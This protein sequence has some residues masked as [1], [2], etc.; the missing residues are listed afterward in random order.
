MRMY[1]IIIKKRNG[2]E[3]TKEEI[4]FFIKGYTDGS[5]PDYQA[6]AL[7]MAIYFQGMNKRE[8]AELTMAMV[9]SGA[10]IDLS[11]ITGVKVD[12]HSTG[13]VGDETSI[14][15][16]NNKIALKLNIP[17]ELKVN[18]KAWLSNIYYQA[19]NSFKPWMVNIIQNSRF[20][21]DNQMLSVTH[22]A[23]ITGI[24]NSTIKSYLHNNSLPSLE[25]IEAIA[26][27]FGTEIESFF[28]FANIKLSK[29]TYNFVIKQSERKAI[30]EY[31][32]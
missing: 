29:E 12:K 17:I 11:A 19:K 23:M 21:K 31:A 30:H 4:Q 6:S 8:T 3:L 28:K 1:D 20:S 5:I 16:I 13:G 25:R 32:F 15:G 18:F 2:E 26:K 10:T 14:N 22:I 27:A 9:N 24:S 7:L